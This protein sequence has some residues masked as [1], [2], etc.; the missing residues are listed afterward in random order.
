MPAAR[1]HHTSV[2]GVICGGGLPA[3]RTSCIDMSGGSWSST[4]FQSI[5]SRW[6]AVT[7]NLNPGASFMILGGGDS[8][9]KRT[10]DIVYTNG[11]VEPGFDL[12]Y[13]TRYVVNFQIII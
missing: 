4:K 10:T 11:T 13:D 9:S 6:G 7:W 5:R 3:E 2:G 8:G 1:Y 12:Q